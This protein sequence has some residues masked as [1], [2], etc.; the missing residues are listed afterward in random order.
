MPSAAA[1]SVVEKSRRPRASPSA[2][3]MRSA[4][5]SQRRWSASKWARWPVRSRHHSPAASAARSSS[6]AAVRAGEAWTPTAS[7]ARARVSQGRRRRAICR[8]RGMAGMECGDV[9]P[10]LTMSLG[11]SPAVRGARR[12]ARGARGDI[13]KVFVRER[14]MCDGERASRRVG[15]S[16][17]ASCRRTPKFRLFRACRGGRGSRRWRRSTP[18]AGRAGADPRGRARR[19]HRRR[20]CCRRGCG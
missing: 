17:A 14:G 20:R 16:K 15:L 7:A 2:P 3:R 12:A 13:N 10:L 1:S 11:S 18:P 8:E 4:A 6:V 5:T 9:S 19:H